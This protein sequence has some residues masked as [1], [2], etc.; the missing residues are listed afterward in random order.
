MAVFV[1]V[2]SSIRGD[3][4]D[5]FSLPGAESQQAY[6]LLAERFPGASG[7]SAQIVF[8][9]QDGASFQDPAVQEQINALL[10]EASGLPHVASIV[11]PY[12]APY[13]VSE[14][15]HDRLRDGEL[16]SAGQ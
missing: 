15:R 5:S 9:T 16:R 11:S 13:Q 6:D 14:D 2:A 8:Q 10:T 7:S 1:A 4:A 3:F 12:D